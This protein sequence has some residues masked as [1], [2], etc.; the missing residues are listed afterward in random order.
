MPTKWKTAVCIRV[1]MTHGYVTVSYNYLGFETE[2]LGCR[3]I[4]LKRVFPFTI[5]TSAAA[6]GRYTSVIRHAT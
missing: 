5:Y 3:G 6:N 2:K 4:V 1:D